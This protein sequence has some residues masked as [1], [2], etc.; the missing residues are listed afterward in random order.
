[1]VGGG[2]PPDAQAIYKTLDPVMLA[3]LTNPQANIPGLLSTAASQVNQLL[4]NG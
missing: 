4:A 2:A 1:V 3:V